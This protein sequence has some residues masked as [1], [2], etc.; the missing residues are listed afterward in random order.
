MC[1]LHTFVDLV[2]R[3]SLPTMSMHA[4][5]RLSLLNIQLYGLNFW[6]R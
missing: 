5:R 1:G 3:V 6:S 4:F 2:S